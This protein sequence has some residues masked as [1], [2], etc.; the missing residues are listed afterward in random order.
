M[1]PI[2]VFIWFVSYGLTFAQT[3]TYKPVKY[4]QNYT[5]NIDIVYTQVNG[6]KGKMDTYIN[7]KAEK[8]TPIV[9]NIHGGGWNHGVKESQRGFGSFFKNGYAVA[10]VAY[11]LVDVATA[12][13]AIQDIRCALIYIYKNAKRL[14]IDT[15]KIV[16]MGGS[17]GGHLALMSGLL[18]NNKKMDINCFFNKKIK[19]AAIINKY[20]VTD[21]VPLKKWRS[22]KKWLGNKIN[23]QKFIE[24]VS[25]I[26]YVNKNSPPIF[27]VHGNEDPIVPYQQSV[28]LH[29]ALKKHNIINDFITIKGG[30]HGKFSKEQKSYI[31]KKMWLFLKELK[32]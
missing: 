21:L 8:P 31:N 10:N 25:P 30:K 23:N 15:T 29:K 16:I 4:P 26:Y 3:R 6:W 18:G 11:R 13:A 14:N 17:A 12:P 7:L 2:F 9:I 19:I 5:A 27:S 22:V 20:G 32:L 28:I 24:S 1:K